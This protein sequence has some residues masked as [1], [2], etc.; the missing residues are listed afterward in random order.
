MEVR[1]RT[2]EAAVKVR[3]MTFHSAKRTPRDTQQLCAAQGNFYTTAS[4]PFGPFRWIQ[5]LS[6][7]ISLI[8]DF[9]I[10]LALPLL[11]RLLGANH[12]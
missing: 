8:R 4:A 3:L 7:A 10:I 1:P 9:F 5:G 11:P 6:S 2:V 12:T